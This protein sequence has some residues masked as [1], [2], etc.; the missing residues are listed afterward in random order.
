MKAVRGLVASLLLSACHPKST[1]PPPAANLAKLEASTTAAARGFERYYRA[2]N[3]GAA[4]AYLERARGRGVP[5]GQREPCRLATGASSS[6]PSVLANPPIAASS[7]RQRSELVAALGAYLVTLAAVADRSSAGVVST[8][9]ANLTTRTLALQKAAGEHDTGDLFID[10]AAAALAKAVDR[11]RADDGG[12]Q[13]TQHLEETD[14]IVRHLIAILASDAARQRAQTVDATKLAFDS[15]L[16]HRNG[17]ATGVM[18]SELPSCSEPAI[19]ERA[20]D[21]SLD[22]G[23]V[24]SDPHGI[25]LRER[26]KAASLADPAPV[27][28]AIAAL[29]DEEMSLLRNPANLADAGKAAAGR[30]LL[31]HV[32]D[33]FDRAAP[34]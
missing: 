12:S 23:G 18:R 30:E 32:A 5:A 11:L 31:A 3:A 27:L 15:W 33:V 28:Q 25:E 24:V 16:A 10:E 29:D 2:E 9:L 14:A 22:A 7:I 19:F 1:A 4:D 6:R 8:S 17:P 26:A 34:Q 21:R 20:H 13:M